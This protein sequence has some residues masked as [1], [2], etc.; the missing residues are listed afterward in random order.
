[1]ALPPKAGLLDRL[2]N[3]LLRRGLGRTAT[4]VSDLTGMVESHPGIAA[5]QGGWLPPERRGR[6]ILVT[7]P[8][9]SNDQGLRAGL[10][11]VRL[12]LETDGKEA[13]H[14]YRRKALDLA[15]NL[16]GGYAIAIYDPILRRLILSRI[17]SA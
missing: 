3:M 7:D 1:M 13:L 6:A 4:R 8:E 11:V 12:L 5:A 10:E 16:P 15:D 9:A 14:L 17:H 2:G